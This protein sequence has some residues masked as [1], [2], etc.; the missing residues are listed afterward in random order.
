M[1]NMTDFTG[2]Y[3]GQVLKSLKS[4]N[5]TK[6]KPKHRF[7]LKGFEI[8]NKHVGSQ[9]NNRSHFPFTLSSLLIVATYGMFRKQ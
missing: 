9:P 1:I 8:N 6:H 5:H 2:P 4:M 3:V 7:Y